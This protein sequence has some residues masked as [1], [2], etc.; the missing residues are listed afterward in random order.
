[1]PGLTALDESVEPLI[2]AL[3]SSQW[4]VLKVAKPGF[5]AITV[6]IWDAHASLC[7]AVK[8]GRSG[9]GL[10]HKTTSQ[11][12]PHR[13]ESSPDRMRYQGTGGVGYTDGKSATPRVASSRFVQSAVFNKKKNPGTGIPGLYLL[14]PGYSRRLCFQWRTAFRAEFL[15]NPKGLCLPNLR[16]PNWEIIQLPLRL[17]YG[18]HD[19]AE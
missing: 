13:G 3:T 4:K 15:R 9:V 12:F 10:S 11:V 1:M 8:G 7:M 16:I 5:V 6:E 17:P 18:S 14:M 19:R 2:S